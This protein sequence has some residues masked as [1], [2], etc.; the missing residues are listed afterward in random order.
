MVRTKMKAAVL[1]KYREFEWREVPTP[2]IRDDQVLVQTRYASICGT[3]QHIFKG[4]FHPRTSVPFIP[5]HEFAGT[6][7][8]VGKNVQG[9]NE[10]DHVVVDPIIWCGECAACKLG[11]YPA[12]K[13]LKLT[14]IDQDG[15][16]G[17]YVAVN[18][19]QIYLLNKDISEC[20]AALVEVLSIGFH[21]CNRAGLVEGDTALIWGAGKIGQCILQTARTITK[22]TIFLVDLQEKRLKIAYENFSDTVT[23]HIR[24]QDPVEIIHEMTNGR[25]VDVAFEAVGHF[26]KIAGKPDPVPGCIKFIRGGGT[27]CVLGLSDEPVSILMKDLIWKEAR[28]VASR[29]SHGEFKTTINHLSDGNL[30]PGILVSEVMPAAQIQEAFIRLEENPMDHLKILLK[31]GDE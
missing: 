24:E 3:D 31:F 29:V 10:G 17:E 4:E 6:V 14:G 1:K 23:I 13:R 27:V 28:I 16:F 2:E 20:D 15:A 30:K 21:A 5:G 18:D 19:K 11:H 25:G 22:N 9:I 8:A 26:E 7:E 12:C